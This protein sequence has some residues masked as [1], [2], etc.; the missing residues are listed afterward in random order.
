MCLSSRNKTQSMLFSSRTIHL[1][2]LQCARLLIGRV[3]TLIL[4]LPTGLFNDSQ[5]NQSQR[6]KD[7]LK[8]SSNH[9]RH[10]HHMYQADN[11]LVG[12]CPYVSFPHL[13]YDDSRA[14]YW[15]FSL[16]TYPLQ[17]KSTQ[18]VHVQ[19]QV[20]SGRLSTPSQLMQRIYFSHKG[21]GSERNI[22][23]MSS[24][25][26]ALCDLQPW[27]TDQECRQQLLCFQTLF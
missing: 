19:S 21:T 3:S 8:P 5:H 4:Y 17:I 14:E 22:E 1:R 6:T 25:R 18:E 2:L 13:T 7:K 15:Y 27:V 20:F 23:L 9:H 11:S 16:C 12:I 26:A 10:Y 24:N